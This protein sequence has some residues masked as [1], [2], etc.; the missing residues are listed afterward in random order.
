LARTLLE[1]ALAVAFSKTR[2]GRRPGLPQTTATEELQ[3][4][5]Y[6]SVED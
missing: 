3:T 2:T 6:L 4:D 1:S 5:L